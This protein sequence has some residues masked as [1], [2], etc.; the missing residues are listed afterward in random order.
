MS[1][2][3]IQYI[4]DKFHLKDFNSAFERIESYLKD[5]PPNGEL[6]YFKALCLLNFEKY[7]E[8]INTLLESIKLDPLNLEKYNST[9]STIYSKI[10]LISFTSKFFDA[11]LISL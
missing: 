3:D 10:G 6:L 5:N 1:A 4:E 8:A 7:E 2:I 9:I 11:S